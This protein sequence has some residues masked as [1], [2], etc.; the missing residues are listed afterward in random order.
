MSP[1]FNGR[2]RLLTAAVL[3]LT[4]LLTLFL[5][6][7][8]WLPL[9]ARFLII[10]QTSLE[11]A[12]LL[13][14]LGGNALRAEGAA[15][16]YHK[17]LAPRLLTTGAL[18][19]KDLQALGL[20][21]P[22]AEVSARALQRHGVPRSA[23][24]ILRQGTST[25]EEAVALREYARTHALRS[26]IIVTSEFHTRRARWIFQK[27]VGRGGIRIQVAAL[28]DA[29]YSAATWWKNEEGLIAFNNE[30]VKLFYYLVRY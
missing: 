2:H 16:L 8:L 10:R 1:D 6:A 13:H 25:Y 11:P 20:L 12:D 14:V 30:W 7:P 17:G 29:D 4:L 18:I 15:R 23:I 22:E 19:P 3:T 24:Q 9:P 5:T 28:P 21:L 27:V 26:V